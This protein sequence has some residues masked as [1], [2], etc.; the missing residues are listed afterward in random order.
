MLLGF[1]LAARKQS[2]GD[3]VSALSN[4]CRLLA[5]IIHEITSLA[6]HAPRCAQ[7]I[8]VEPAFQNQRGSN[9]VHIGM[10]AASGSLASAS[11]LS[12]ALLCRHG[13][14]ALV[15]EMDWQG[16]VLFQAFGK[17]LYVIAQGLLFTVFGKWPPYNQVCGLP[18][19]DMRVDRLPVWRAVVITD[20]RER[21]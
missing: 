18:L 19:F 14:I 1:K 20:Y 3:S 16:I 15:S 12:Y 6:M 10:F 7:L 5:W 4:Y 11:H 8:E 9:T 21:A 13:T 17:S 2:N